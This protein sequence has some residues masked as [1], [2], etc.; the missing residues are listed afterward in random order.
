MDFFFIPC[1][2][3][4]V[5]IL[6]RISDFFFSFALSTAA[7]KVPRFDAQFELRAL[8]V[9]GGLDVTLSPADATVR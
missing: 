5:T 1:W 9:Y 2:S 4:I 7:R 8:T 6:A 3:F